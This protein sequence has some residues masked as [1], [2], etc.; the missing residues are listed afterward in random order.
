MALAMTS[1][2]QEFEKVQSLTF[3]F[4][5]QVA[6]GFYR[7]WVF[8]FGRSRCLIEALLKIFGQWSYTHYRIGSL[9]TFSFCHSIWC[10]KCDC[11]RRWPFWRNLCRRSFSSLYISIVLRKEQ[12]VYF[13][14]QDSM[15]LSSNEPMNLTPMISFLSWLLGHIDLSYCAFYEY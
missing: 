2:L 7:M 11:Y 14:S 5:H 4:L 3:Y 15:K 8:H 9:L 10:L 6:A 1:A 13:A 12:S